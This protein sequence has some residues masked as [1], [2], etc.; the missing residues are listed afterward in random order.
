[1][2]L[3]IDGRLYGCLFATNGEDLRAALRDGASDEA[4]RRRIS[5]LWQQREDRYSE[6]RHSR[7][8]GERRKIEMSYIG[9]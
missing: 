1:L 9:G 3:S 8:S 2:R 7:S 6:L 5:G 4:L